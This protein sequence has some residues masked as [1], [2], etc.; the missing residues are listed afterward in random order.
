MPGAVGTAAS[1]VVPSDGPF[2]ET[3]TGFDWE[4]VPPDSML[5]CKVQDLQKADSPVRSS[6]FPGGETALFRNL[7]WHR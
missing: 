1:E 2:G 6:D 3:R 5:A 7:R 4:P